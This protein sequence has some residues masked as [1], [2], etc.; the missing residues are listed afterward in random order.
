MRLS[1]L[2]AALALAGCASAHSQPRDVTFQTLPGGTATP[3]A[4]GKMTQFELQQIVQRFT[5]TFADNVLETG[6]PVVDATE[7]P[8]IQ[9]QMLA[10]VTSYYTAALDVASGALPEVSVLDM[11]VF[12]RLSRSVIE[13]H[14]KPKVFGDSIDPLLETFRASEQKVWEFSKTLLGEKER[15]TL[16][17]LIDD[18]LEL[19]PNTLQVEMV[20]FGQFAERAGEVSAEMSERAEGLIGS[21]RGATLIVSQGLL[22]GERAMFHANRLPTVIRLQTR[23]GAMEVVSDSLNNTQTLT[24]ALEGLPDPD[25]M[26]RDLTALTRQSGDLLRESRATIDALRPLLGDKGVGATIDSTNRLADKGLELVHEVKGLKPHEAQLLATNVGTDFDRLVR[27]MVAYLALLGAV[28]SGIF[29]GAYY[30]VKRLLPE[31]TEARKSGSNGIRH[32]A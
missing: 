1:L 3:G 8:Q 12:L 17:G 21:V 16:I 32:R 10:R 20:R 25:P 11:L 15:Q 28:S 19:H 14:W 27:R 24:R 31:I 9:R 5:S 2:L 26:I 6:L 7:D 18:W 29:W 4:G 13:R 23:L 22:L 30:L